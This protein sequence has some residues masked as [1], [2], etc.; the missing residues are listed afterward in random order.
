L[1]HAIVSVTNDL[2]TDQRV[3]RVCMTLVRLGFEVLLVGRKKA[4]SP[5]LPDRDYRMHRMKLL[6]EKGFLFYAEYNIRLFVLLLFGKT[7]LLIANDLDTLLPNFLV[8]KLKRRPLVYDSHELFTETPEVIHRPFVKGVWES[9]EK[10]IFP[11]LKDVF[12]V[13]ESIAEIF[14]EKYK[15]NV[16]VVR[17]VPVTKFVSQIKSRQDLNLPDNVKI[18]ILQGSGINIQRGVEE[19]VLSMKKLTGFLLLIIGD[20]DVIATL[21]SMVKELELEKSV[22]FYPRLP[23]DELHQFTLNADL[24]LTIDK[25]TNLNYRYSLPNK[26]FDYIHASIPVL[27]SPLAE[28]RKIVEKYDIGLLIKNHDPEHIADQIN[29]AMSDEVRIGKWKEN[30]KFAARE[31]CWE[32]EVEV[33]TGVYQKYV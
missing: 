27:A 11:K 4:S 13:S 16:Q 18:L 7:G 23:V 14:R 3:D 19:L 17:N 25:D 20:G 33:I 32:K 10:W 29:L 22:W 28:V 6:F 26:L 9:I 21:K 15:V 2:V 30:C 1:K 31:L 8:H 24:G 12:T 5:P